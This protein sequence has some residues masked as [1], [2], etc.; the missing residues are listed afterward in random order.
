MPDEIYESLIQPAGRQYRNNQVKA[1]SHYHEPIDRSVGRLAGN[2]RVWGDASPDVQSR[3]IDTLISASRERGLSPRETAYVLAIARIESGFNPDAAAGTTSASGLG[4]FIDDTGRG[5]G[6]GSTNH[7]DVDAQAGALA[8]HFMENRDLALSRGQGEEYV[9]KYHH[10][11]PSRD[12]GGLGLSRSEV[13]PW[14]DGYERFV[15]HRLEPVQAGISRQQVPS[16][17][18]MADGLFRQGDHGE[19]I[20]RLQ[21][22]LNQLGFRDTH[23]HVLVEDSTFGR[24]TKEALEAFQRA[25]GLKADGIAG[26]NT[27][28]RIAGFPIPNNGAGIANIGETTATTLDDAGHPGHALYKQ[29]YDRILEQHPQNLG[30]SSEQEVR[31][32]AGT[33]AFEAAVSGLRRID[34]VIGNQDA[35]GLLAIQGALDDPGQRRVYVDRVQATAQ[36]LERSSQLFM[37]EHQPLVQVQAQPHENARVLTQH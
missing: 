9:Y 29:A 35:S 32:V 19:E 12:Y 28:E 5:Y 25:G 18:G 16:Q 8:R 6:L 34:H 33:L 30:L 14:L 4:Q 27:L 2:S 7:F 10:D 23:G 13:A 1:W 36:P 22:S 21:H 26:P 11:G 24:H 17:D 37:Q 31:N 15:Q 3:V 20:N